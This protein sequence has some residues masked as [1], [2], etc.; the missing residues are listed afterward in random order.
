MQNNIDM[1]GV[2]WEPI[3]EFNGI[4]NG[5]GYTISNL[6]ITGNNSN[7]GLFGFTSDGEVKN[8]TVNN[9]EV[10]GD[11]CFASHTGVGILRQASIQNR[12]R[13]RICHLVR[14]ARINFFKHN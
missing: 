6:K 10:S 3:T 11:H 13:N 9:A 5:N 4:F 1:N 12:I 8:L 7:V 14:V 2:E